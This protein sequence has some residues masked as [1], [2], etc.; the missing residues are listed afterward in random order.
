MGYLFGLFSETIIISGLV[1]PMASVAI[2]TVSKKLL[3][4]VISLLFPKLSLNIYSIISYKFLFEISANVLLAP[5]VFK[6]LSFF[7]AQLSI[8]D[9]KDMIDNG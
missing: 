6:F 4:F 5:L 8:R 9:T 7:K 3:I 2:G 1:I